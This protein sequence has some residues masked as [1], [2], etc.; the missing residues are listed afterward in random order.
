MRHSEGFQRREVLI[1]PKVSVIIP[2]YNHERFVAEAIESVLRQTY[3]DFELIITDDGSTDGTVDEIRKFKDPRI[4]LFTFAKNQGACIAANKCIAEAQGEYVAM[5]SSDDAFLPDKLEKQVKFLDSNPGYAAV[6]GYAELFDE[7]GNGLEIEEAS[8]FRPLKNANR[9]RYEWLRAFFCEGN[10]L[11]HPTILIRKK[12]YDEIGGYDARYAQLPDFAFFIRLLLKHEIHVMEDKL[13]KFR[14]RKGELNVSGDRPAVRCRLSWEYI[15]FLEQYAAIGSANEL[16]AIFP[17]AKGK[18]EGRIDASLIPFVVA[19]L[20]LEAGIHEPYRPAYQVFAFNTLFELMSRPDIAGRLKERCG[21][22]YTDLIRLTGEYDYSNSIKVMDLQARA[23][24]MYLESQKAWRRVEELNARL[25]KTEKALADTDKKLSDTE[26]ALADTGWARAEAERRLHEVLLS[27]TWRYAD[28][29]RRIANTALP[30]GSMRRE[31]VKVPYKLSKAVLHIGAQDGVKVREVRNSRWPEDRPLLS[32]VIPCFNYGGYIDEAIDSVL[33]QTFLNLEIIV[34]EGGS[35]DD[36]TVRKLRALNRP[37]TTVYFREGPRLVGDNRNF[38]IEKAR[39]KYICCLDADDK[40]RPTYIEKALFLAENFNCDIVYPSVQCF[41]ESDIVWNAD[42]ASF[43]RIAEGN[44]I[45]T[46]AVF[47]KDAWQKAGGYRDWGLG[48]DHLPE[49]WEFW[50]RLLGLGFRARRLPEPLMLY[51][52]HGSGLTAGISKSIE[53]QVETIKEANRGLFKE[54][55]LKRLERLNNIRYSVRDPYV[56]LT[57]PDNSDKKILFAL[58][59]M[60][61]GGAD[62]VLLQIAQYLTLNGFQISCVTTLPVPEQWGDNT[63]RYEK[64]TGEIYHLHKFLESTEQWKDFIFYLME[65]R[66]IDVV[67]IVGC[68]YMY[69]LLPEIK[70]R[71]PHVRVVDQL[72]NEHGHIKNNRQFSDFIDCNIV[73]NST[74]RDVLINKYKEPPGKV[75]VVI[76]GVDVREEFNPE[77]IGAS[78]DIVPG[79]KFIVG[80]F[81]RFSEEKR[82]ETFVDIMEALSKEEDI[83]FV[84]TGGGPMYHDIKKRVDGCGLG[85]KAYVPGIVDDIRPILAKTGVLVIPSRIEGIPIIL[86]EAMSMGVP[87]IASDVGGIPSVIRDGYN[88]FLCPPDDPQAFIDRVR[89]LHGDRRLRDDMA[90][91]ARDYAV[92]NLDIATMNRQYYNIFS[93]IIGKR[94]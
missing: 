41:E 86:L 13:I 8:Y 27:K 55:N 1:M 16:F 73:A 88:G 48:K 66:R 77:R 18:Y 40:L 76:H 60:I 74:V 11:I 82:P 32:V 12:I 75:E 45:S 56:N 14:I 25:G 46:V 80:Y 10:K 30:K 20:A 65:T 89:L 78:D 43:P 2:S 42:N 64:I 24:E 38:G 79:D 91:N 70:Q 54:R 59:F 52:V 90:K 36:S 63:P 17:N 21:F 23:H 87:A 49:D 34:V 81:G 39:G 94:D 68:E 61:M 57:R 44:M 58:P 85:Q 3:D 7:E 33:A 19:M 84:M 93:G 53:E 62:T 71:F 28:G 51:R 15:H 35:T 9:S 67:F 29:I 50:T 72:F 47:R 5:L 4:R 22:T 92:G 6:F 37:R 83:R 26:K 31:A 69:R